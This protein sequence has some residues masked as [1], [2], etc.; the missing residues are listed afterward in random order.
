[1]P[2]AVTQTDRLRLKHVRLTKSH[3]S[4]LH[5]YCSALELHQPIHVASAMRKEQQT[6]TQ[7]GAHLKGNVEACTT[8]ESA[9]PNRDVACDDN[10]ISVDYYM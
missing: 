5:M 10:N 4:K 1:M 8:R 6:M 2:I 3:N 9:W 7:F